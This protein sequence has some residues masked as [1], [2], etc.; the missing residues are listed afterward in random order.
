[1]HRGADAIRGKIYS[2]QIYTLSSHGLDLWVLCYRGV[3][4][5][6]GGAACRTQI[7]LLRR[8]HGQHHATIMTNDFVVNSILPSF[9]G[10]LAPPYQDPLLQHSRLGNSAE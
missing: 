9:S 10:M 8:L 7:S 2:L 1:M 5:K 3:G 4:V 6:G